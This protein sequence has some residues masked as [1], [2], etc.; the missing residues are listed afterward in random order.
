MAACDWLM[1]ASLSLNAD[2]FVG[3][4][5]EGPDAG[6][7]TPAYGYEI[8]I[9]LMLTHLIPAHS[10]SPQTPRNPLTAPD[11]SNATSAHTSSATR[12][13]RLKSLRTFE[14]ASRVT[15]AHW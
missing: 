11:P 4:H 5:E 3:P 15:E 9:P 14:E 6:A 8:S 12:L 10:L 2:I 1:R 13:V 7:S